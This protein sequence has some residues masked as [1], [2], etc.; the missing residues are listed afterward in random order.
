MNKVEILKYLT[1][2]APYVH[3]RP[4]FLSLG[5]HEGKLEMSGTVMA[6]SSMDM[7]LERNIAFDKPKLQATFKADAVYSIGVEATRTRKRYEEN[8]E[9]AVN[10]ILATHTAKI[11][12][13][14][15]YYE[16]ALK[17]LNDISRL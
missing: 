1:E 7:L 16:D 6:V 8:I 3:N 14:L 17:A 5:F 2:L 15:N 9:R 4:Y 10:L 13:T 12:K 11:I